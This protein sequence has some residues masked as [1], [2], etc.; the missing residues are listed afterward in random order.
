[1]R[2]MGVGVETEDE[3]ERLY[4]SRRAAFVALATA[5]TGDGAEAIDVVQ[6]AFATA[7]RKRRGIRAKDSLEPWLWRIVLNKARDRRR[8]QGRGFSV[9]PV[10]PAVTTNGYEADAAVRAVLSE[11]P[12]RQRETIFLR[13]YADLDYAAIAELLGISPGTVAATLNAAHAAVREQ[14]EGV[15]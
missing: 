14:I 13:Y 12:E 6:E 1:M 15:R 4:R 9:H 10:E 8:K 3:I 5:V 11:L 7:L 2:H